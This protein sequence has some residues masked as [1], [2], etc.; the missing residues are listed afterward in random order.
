LNHFFDYEH[1]FELIPARRVAVDCN[2]DCNEQQMGMFDYSVCIASV[3][4]LKRVIYEW[5]SGLIF[6]NL[7]Y[8]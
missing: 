5:M 4:E 8:M 7:M 1:G 3:T 2:G 6:K